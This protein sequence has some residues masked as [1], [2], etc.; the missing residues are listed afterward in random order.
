MVFCNVVLRL[1]HSTLVTCRNL[2]NGLERN[3]E[4]RLH[5][6]P[7]PSSDGTSIPISPSCPRS[8]PSP[9][10]GLAPNSFTASDFRN[11][12]QKSRPSPLASESGGSGGSVSNH[13]HQ[14][15]YSHNPTSHSHYRRPREIA[16]PEESEPNRPNLALDS[17]EVQKFVDPV[18]SSRFLHP[19]ADS[20]E[21]EVSFTATSKYCHVPSNVLI[22][23]PTCTSITPT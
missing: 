16:I 20:L 15:L 1:I 13:H 21:S 8:S 12:P 2:L 6:C 11:L 10:V 22:H 3:K 14:Q 23:I 4:E 5:P 9:R 18:V 17:P 7:P 19:V